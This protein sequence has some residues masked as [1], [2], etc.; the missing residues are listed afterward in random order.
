MVD[1]TNI[2]R[3]LRGSTHKRGAKETRGRKRLYSRRNVLS[4]NAARRKFIKAT[5]GT[6]RITWDLVAANGRAPKGN[7]TIVARA[8][9]RERI[10][11]KLR[12]NCEKPQRTKDQEKERETRCARMMRWPLKRF[13][14]EIDFIWDS[15]RFPIPTTPEARA[16]LAK[17]KVVVQL[18]TPREGL[19][20]HFTKPG[21]KAHRNNM[22][23][24]HADVCAGISNNRIVLWEYHTR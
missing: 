13:T 19:E 12:R 8:F 3:F 20:E 11:V 2:R 10:P 24:G 9:V 14:E 16:Y 6:C 7:R 5:K 4:M 15:K 22:G 18:R 21:P 1:I 17:Q 23:G